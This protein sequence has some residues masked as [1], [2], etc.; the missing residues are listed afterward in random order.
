MTLY[1]VRHGPTH[2]KGMTGWTDLP[3]D[4]SDTATLARL[5]AALPAARVVSSDLAR[6]IA[7]ADAL[8]PGPRLP[9]DRALREIH[10]GAW[11]GLTHDQAEARD[12]ALLRAFWD[13]PGA[14]AAPGGESWNALAAR[15]GAALDRL[16]GQDT[17]IVA[18]FGP[19][20]A[21]IGWATGAAPRD[22][23]THRIEPLSLTILS[24]GHVTAINRQP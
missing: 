5:R 18:H 17:V 9:H 19:I 21:A 10:F 6:A 11:E 22:L 13:A 14:I 3:A 23:F 2:A 4:L 1:L 24:R 20:L 16:E 15:V 7:T 8:S 12:P